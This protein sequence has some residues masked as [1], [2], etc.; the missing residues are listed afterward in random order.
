MIEVFVVDDYDQGKLGGGPRTQCEG[1]FLLFRGS[2]RL[3]D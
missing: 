2:A 1:L 3:F